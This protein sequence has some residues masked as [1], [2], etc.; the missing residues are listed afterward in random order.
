MA[1]IRHYM[2]RCVLNWRKIFLSFTF[3]GCSFINSLFQLFWTCVDVVSNY[4]Y[5]TKA[6]QIPKCLVGV[7]LSGRC[8]CLVTKVQTL[9]NLFWNYR[10]FMYYIIVTTFTTGLPDGLGPNKSISSQK[11]AKKKLNL[12]VKNLEHIIIQCR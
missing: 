12:I 1:F 7:Q 4:M 2:L 11:K 8:Y 6:T 9:V 10:Q 3:N 5:S